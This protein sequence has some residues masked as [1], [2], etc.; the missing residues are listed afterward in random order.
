M[1]IK[2]SSTLFLVAKLVYVL[3]MNELQHSVWLVS[4]SVNARKS[5]AMPEFTE[6]CINHHKYLSLYN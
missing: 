5:H 6:Q 2:K 4:V 3:R 1:Q